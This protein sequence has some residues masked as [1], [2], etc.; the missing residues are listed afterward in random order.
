[1]KNRNN[2][3][4]ITD[5]DFMEGYYPEKPLT[6]AE[7]IEL[8][9]SFDEKIRSNKKSIFK[10]L[11]HLK[12]LK[13]YMLSKDVKWYRKSVVIAAIMYFIA[14][15]DAVPDLAPLIGFL[16]DFGVIAWTIRFLGKE[17]TDYYE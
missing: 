9:K 7:E 13:K 10:V 11:G 8:E 16:D 5:I 2:T 3:K 17:I 6:K 12:A 14:P 4:D 1:M 15:I